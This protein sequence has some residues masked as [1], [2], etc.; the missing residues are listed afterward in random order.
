MPKSIVKNYRPTAGIDLK[1]ND[2]LRQ[3]GF[4]SGGQNC[5]YDD[6]QNML[7]RFGS[8]IKERYVNTGRGG[9][10]V[11]EGTDYKGES[12][13]ELLALGSTPKKLVKESIKITA[14]GGDYVAGFHYNPV[15]GEYEFT[16]STVA[17]ALL[18]TQ[19]CGLGTEGT[20]YHTAQLSSAID[21]TAQFSV[22]GA[23]HIA[24][25]AA[26]CEVLPEVRINAGESDYLYYYVWHSVFTAVG[27]AITID[28]GYADSE[29]S[30]PST[31]KIGSSL[32]ITTASK[33]GA[34]K[35][36]GK[37]IHKYDGQSFY[38]V[39]LP[40]SPLVNTDGI[41]LY[42][43][44]ATVNDCR[45]QWTAPAVPTGK[46]AKYYVLTF[47]HLDK[48]GRVSEGDYDRDS[49]ARGGAHTVV[50]PNLMIA[51][52]LTENPI[53]DNGYND[54]TSIASAAKSGGTVITAASVNNVETGDVVRFFDSAQAK[55][56]SR[57]IVATTATTFTL[58][59][60]AINSY[61]AGGNISCYIGAVFSTMQMSIWSTNT[62]NVDADYYL[63]N[64]VPF[65]CTK[66]NFMLS[67]VGSTGW[68][69]YADVADGNT[70]GALL[71]TPETIRAEPPI[72]HIVSEYNGLL[73]VSGIKDDPK[74]VSFGTSE[75]I[76]NHPEAT[77]S[78]SMREDV[79]GIGQSGHTMNVF[80]K[81][82]IDY[83]YGDLSE[84]NFRV[85]RIA[86][87]IGCNSHH[88]IVEVD[89]GII[90]FQSL[91]GPY[92]LT[93]GRNL[94]PLGAW[95]DG[96]SSL[97]EPYFVGYYPRLDSGVLA[98]YP[99]FEHSIATVDQKR[100]LYFLHIPWEL[101]GEENEG[102]DLSVTW[103]FDYGVGAWLPPWYGLNYHAG[104]TVY[105]D[106]LWGMVYDVGT[107]IC[108]VYAELK[109]KGI[110]SYADHS[111]AIDAL[112]QSHW[113]SA[114]DPN[115]YK[116]FLRL[117]IASVGAVENQT[118]DLIV[119]TYP[120]YDELTVMTE[121]TIT[122]VAREIA[123]LK[124]KSGKCNSLMIELRN[125]TIH[126]NFL[127]SGWDLTF[128][129][130]YGKPSSAFRSDD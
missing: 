95:Q 30:L 79:T 6:Q 1:S 5:R 34:T 119:R 33:A 13:T 123:R 56:I 42:G 70:V 7:K 126:Q 105:E 53:K 112:K 11:Y 113:E 57:E 68:A 122:A 15:S 8:Q 101:E 9:L 4:L 14:T 75:D 92:V 37:Y 76:E 88:S 98:R 48:T 94:A 72:G 104:M 65:D 18:F 130:A 32:Y 55:F 61:D 66:A 62:G 78:F 109:D 84:F 63:M 17:G 107:D 111:V 103:V 96:K 69:L 46:P 21:A 19:G 91:R 97:L 124:L 39:G 20:P 81:S 28:H 54:H 25:P 114:G 38:R 2:I 74:R 52:Q 73:I 118:W 31:V 99:A 77:N 110:Y 49:I 26:F 102:S 121:A 58:S 45:G 41:G 12:K 50:G 115:S 127:I 22:V 23:G 47:L 60:E 36:S 51:L 71:A 120:N 90:A 89:E 83:V 117:A 64:E 27:G 59:T 43:G 106:K 3:A 44:G 40:E 128:A 29:F 16:I 125:N 35:N 108:R 87:N 24:V 10:V 82:T 129:M 86:E 100:K 93:A 80:G 116:K 67:G 85:D